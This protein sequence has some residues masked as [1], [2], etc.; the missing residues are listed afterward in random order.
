MEQEPCE[1]M[2]TI[3]ASERLGIH[4]SLRTHRKHRERKSRL[5]NHRKIFSHY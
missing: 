3:Y 1:E 5:M 4:H 2:A